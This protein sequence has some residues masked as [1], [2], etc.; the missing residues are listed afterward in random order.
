MFCKSCG[1]KNDAGSQF[2]LQCG[3]KL[4]TDGGT[5][6]I[7]LEKANKKNKKNIFIGIGVIIFIIIV[8]SMAMNGDK[9]DYIGSVKTMKPF[10][11]YDIS[12]SYETVLSKYFTSI[13]WAERVSSKELA[14]VDVSGKIK[15]SD[16]STRDIA[17]TFRVTPYEGKT[18]DMI[19]IEPWILEIDESGYDKSIAD[20]FVEELF[21][22]YA[23]GYA[24][25]AD[26]WNAYE[27]WDWE[28]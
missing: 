10:E 9:T 4:I 21:D 25:M 20:E 17:I 27:D 2:C 22:A 13:K 8:I 15:D 23:G 11:D 5:V 28:Y 16:G 3:E 6:A 24:T 26:Y 1:A 14:Y 12:A 18:K 19:W 7:P